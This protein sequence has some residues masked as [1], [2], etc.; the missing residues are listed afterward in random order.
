MN[1]KLFLRCIVL[2]IPL[3]LACPHA[4]AWFFF[5]FPLPGGSSKD[6][7]SIVVSDKD[8]QVGKCAGYHTNQR[9]STAAIQTFSEAM[10]EKLIP[11]AE[12]KENVKELA[13]IYDSRWAQAGKVDMQTNRAYGA[14]LAVACRS[15]GIPIS[16]A[17]QEAMKRREEARKAEDVQKLEEAKRQEEAQKL[18]EAKRQE[19]AQKLE[20]AR[21]Q[22]EVQKVE[23][24]K[25]QEEAQK[26]EEAKRQEEAQKIEEARQRALEKLPKNA[27]SAKAPASKMIDFNFEARKSA[28]ILGCSTSD[29]K[30][31]GVEGKNIVYVANCD[32]STSLTLLCDP[33]GLCLKK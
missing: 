20:E 4:N 32:R 13:G 33:T 5:W 15:L 18:E 3:L 17:D 12:D 1:R 21:R 26:L 31:A 14:G 27:P 22:E 11:L 23:E 30:V 9:R 24:A 28:R 10:L 16:I 29:L 8:R 6:P 19:E 25:R 2:C 7:D